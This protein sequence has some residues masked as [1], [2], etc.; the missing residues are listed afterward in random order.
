MSKLL[1]ATGLLAAG[2]AIGSA[3]AYIVLH[4][5]ETPTSLQPAPASEE[6]RPERTADGRIILYL[7]HGEQTHISAE[8][9]AFLQGLQTLH[10]AAL[11]EDRPLLKSTAES[12][13]RGDGAG[14]TIQQKAPEG[15]RRIGQSLRQDFGVI[16]DMAMTAPLPEIQQS[17]NETMY[18]CIACHGSY[19]A[20]EIEAP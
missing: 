19:A 3:V 8:M 12:L 16:S 15:F 13:R 7:D 9:R 1:S 10:E 20:V 2:A 4:E 5:P 18:K 17:L 6:A 14:R 11:N